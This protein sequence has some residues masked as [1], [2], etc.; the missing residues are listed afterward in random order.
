M[1]GIVTLA[2]ALALPEGF[3]ARPLLVFTA[4]F[5]TIGTLVLQGMTLRQLLL[6]LNAH[7]EIS[8][9]DERRKARVELASAALLALEN[10]TTDD[11]GLLE[12]LLLAQRDAAMAEA[13]GRSGT[14]DLRWEILLGAVSADRPKASTRHRGRR[15]PSSRG[16]VRSSRA[17]APSA[18]QHL[19][20]NQSRPA[21]QAATFST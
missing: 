14:A 13:E 7:D 2:S 8:V 10:T 15:L 6:S 1:R 9:D 4:F 11:A 5:V 17:D 18:W 19:T 20:S 12:A 3:P 16:R 21:S